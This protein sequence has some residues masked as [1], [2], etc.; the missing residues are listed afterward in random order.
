MAAG[1]LKGDQ[2]IED[3]C[4]KTEGRIFST[5]NFELSIR[6]R[7]ACTFLKFIF[8]LTKRNRHIDVDLNHNV[9]SGLL[10]VS[11]M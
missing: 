5:E 9:L 11:I 1:E 7:L 6:Y 4:T 10:Q 3:K 2:L 8:F